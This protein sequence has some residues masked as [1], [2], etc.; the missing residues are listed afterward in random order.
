MQ[1]E[2]VDFNDFFAPVIKQAMLRAVLAMV[3]VVDKTAFDNAHL[4]EVIYVE[5]PSKSLR[6]VDGLM[7]AVCLSPGTACVRYRVHGTKRFSS[8][9]NAWVCARCDHVGVLRS[10]CSACNEV[11]L[12]VAVCRG[13]APR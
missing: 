3:A 12:E 11:V 4:M 2:V 1:R 7:W 9:T 8:S 5:Q 10:G 6:R 13:L